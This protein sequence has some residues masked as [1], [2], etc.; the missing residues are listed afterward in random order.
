MTKLTITLDIDNNDTGCPDPKY[1]GPEVTWG[2]FLKLLN[3][4]TPSDKDLS[5]RDGLSAPINNDLMIGH[6]RIEV[7]DPY[8]PEGMLL[9]QARYDFEVNAWSAS[10][11]ASG[12]TGGKID[13]IGGYG[14]R[15]YWRDE[16]E[17]REPE[18]VD[19]FDKEF[20]LHTE[21]LEVALSDLKS[22]PWH[23]H[24]GG[25]DA[26]LD[27]WRRSF[28]RRD[29]W[30]VAEFERQAEKLRPQPEPEF[31]QGMVVR[32]VGGTVYVK[33]LEEAWTGVYVNGHV[34][35][36]SHFDNMIRNDLATGTGTIIFDPR[37]SAL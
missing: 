12:I 18:S 4:Y 27:Y 8:V 9:K 13:A 32:H 14:Q 25:F 22:N 17:K 34:N 21:R 10:S 26:Q 23:E 28:T 19:A 11:N 20:P 5:I 2:R 29:P 3:F 37:N 33:G 31:A 30:L 24:S 36:L 16:L 35:E 15:L 6:L 1:N 7:A